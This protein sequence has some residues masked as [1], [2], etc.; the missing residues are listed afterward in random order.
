VFVKTT[1]A[2]QRPDGSPES[3]AVSASHEL[4]E[5]LADPSIN[6]MVTGPNLR[7]GYAY[8]VADPVEETDFPVS[9]NGVT[10]RISNFVTPEYFETF[11]HA[12]PVAYDHLGLCKKPFQLLSGGYQS[13]WSGGRWSNVFGS[14]GKAARFKLED[15]TGHRTESRGFP[16]K[17]RK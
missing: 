6:M 14:K 4:W 11:K 17:L 15:R 13:I 3:V 1:L 10:V 16:T 2:Q 5:M 12:Q 9:I 8:E 7:A